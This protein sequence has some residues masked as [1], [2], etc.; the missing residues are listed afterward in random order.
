MCNNLI[1]VGVKKLELENFGGRMESLTGKTGKSGRGQVFGKKTNSAFDVVRFMWQRD[2]L[3][4]VGSK[5]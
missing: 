3:W 2:N 5:G 4:L 1:A